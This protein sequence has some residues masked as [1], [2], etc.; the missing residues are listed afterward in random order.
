MG[1]NFALVIQQK[2]SEDNILPG[3]YHHA[4]FLGLYK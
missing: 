3:V 2:N 4:E 1:T